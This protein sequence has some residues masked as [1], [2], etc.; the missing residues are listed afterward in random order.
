[1][2]GAKLLTNFVPKAEIGRKIEL[3][4]EERE[5]L[6]VGGGRFRVKGEK[7]V[8]EL[9]YKTRN[10]FYLMMLDTST[11][12]LLTKAKSGNFSAFF[13]FSILTGSSFK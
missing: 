5:K 12:C 3:L 2:R 13:D 9:H 10:N 7:G 4:A 1:M 6:A 8:T 11:K